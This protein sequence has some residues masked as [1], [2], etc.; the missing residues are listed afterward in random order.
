MLIEPFTPSAHND[1]VGGAGG[2]GWEM[3]KPS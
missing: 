2:N 1:G 3:E